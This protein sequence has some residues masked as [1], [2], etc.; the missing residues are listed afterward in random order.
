MSAGTFVGAI[1]AYGAGDYRESAA[2]PRVSGVR[3]ADFGLLSS[4]GRRW[5]I[6]FY[7][8]FFCIGVA[9]Q[10]AATDVPVF[11]VGRVFAGLGVGGVSCL[12][13]MY[14][15]ETAPRFIRGAIVSGESRSELARGVG[16]CFVVLT[17][18]TSVRLPM[19][20]H[21]RKHV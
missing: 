14:Q 4:V 9:L 7:L 6:C 11:T 13:P 8:V 16:S 5:G 2:I 18:C 3:A 17:C 19:V 1:T 12:V 21:S 20:H 10:V 15:S